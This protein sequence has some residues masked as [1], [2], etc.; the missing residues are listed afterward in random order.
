MFNQLGWT[1][2][3]DQTENKRKTRKIYDIEKCIPFL[4]R[5]IG[6]DFRNYISDGDSMGNRPVV[7]M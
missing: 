4:N 2:C 7:D 6:G 1:V 3:W 5:L